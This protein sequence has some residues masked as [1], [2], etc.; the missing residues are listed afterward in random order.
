[1]IILSTKFAYEAIIHQFTIQGMNDKKLVF[2]LSIIERK[3]SQL[4]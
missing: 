4:S 2:N 3:K 1:M